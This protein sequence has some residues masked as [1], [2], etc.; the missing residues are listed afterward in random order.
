MASILAHAAIPMILRRRVS[1]PGLERRL[2]FVAV[3]CAIWPDVDLATLVFEVRPNE[4]LGHRGLTHSLIVAAVVSV[5]AAGLAFRALRLGS[6]AWWRV[7]GFLFAVSAAHG[8]LDALTT[9]DG[10]ALFAPITNVRLASPFKL[11][12][13]CPLGLDEYL[14]RFGMLTFANEVLYVVMPLALVV[15]W[16]EKEAPRTRLTMIAVAWCASVFALRATLPDLFKPTVPRI[17]MPALTKELESIRHDD[18]PDGKLVTRIDELRA[19]GLFDRVLVPS[20]PV[21]SSSFFPSWFGAESGRWMDGSPRLVWRTLF[22]FLPPT[23]ARAHAWLADPQKVFSLA[24][25]EKVD[26]AFGRFDFPATTE[27]LSFT[28]NARPRPRYWFGRCNGVAA[29]ATAQP[30]PFRVVDVIGVSGAH[31]RFHPND[32]KALLAVAYAQPEKY[33]LIG[34]MCETV[35]FDPGATCSMNPALLV[36]TLLN[37]MGIAHESLVVDV[38]PSIGNQYYAVA[39]ARVRIV[40]EPRTVGDVPMA[41]ALVGQAASL[42]DVAIDLTL[43]STTL[44]YAR[45]NVIDP[46]DPSGSRYMRV[47]VVPVPFAYTPLSRST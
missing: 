9:G 1:L 30:E 20:H 42:V 16:L 34:E 18:L 19:R 29:A 13:C 21:W 14:G 39:D 25:T 4:P 12:P 24:P 44:A 38:I 43:S 26:L 35:A 5:L 17:M 23:E 37:R 8:L 33:T 3:L 10:V 40:G 36:V 7:F 27:A 41:Q 22:G 15:S 11:L 28:H 6:R 32:I 2:A 45:A 31:I 47:G 46:T